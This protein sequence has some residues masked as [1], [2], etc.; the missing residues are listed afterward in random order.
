LLA[1][2]QMTEE[3]VNREKL[4][5]EANREKLLGHYEKAISMLRELH[6]E[7]SENAAVAYELGRLLEAKG[8][9]EEAIRFLRLAN[10]NDPENEWYPKYLADLYQKEGRNAEGAALYERLV[11][12][13][14]DD[15]YLYFR[16]A[17]FLVRSQE[18]DKA[19]KAYDELEKRIGLNEEI[20]RRKHTLFLGMGDTKRAG[21]EL[22]RLVEA[23]PRVLEYKHLLAD[24]YESQGDQSAARKVY[25]QI[26][27]VS[28]DDPEAL[29]A[30]AGGSNLKQ[31]ELR[32]LEELI[33]AFERTDVDLDLKISKLYPFITMVAE[34]GDRAVADAALKL[35]DVMENVHEA[36]AKPYAA[37]GDLLYYSNRPKEAIEKYRATVKR[38]ENVFPVWEQLLRSL[39]EIGNNKGLYGEANNALDV[40]PNRAIIQYYLAIAADALGEYEEALDAISTAEIMSGRDAGLL[41]EVKALEGQVHQHRNNKGEATTAFATARELAAQS[42]DV[43]YRYGLFLLA[44]NDLKAAKDA[45]ETAIKGDAEHPYYNFAMAGVAYAQEDFAKAEEFLAT[46]REKGARY[47]PDAMELSG[48]VQFKLNNVEEAVDFWQQAKDLGGTHQRLTDKITNRSL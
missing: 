10:D 44:N 23:F 15:Q 7:D 22:E 11:A 24:F 12:Q 27:E 5:I 29:L 43:N 41:A 42:P 17:Y 31:D 6:R 3:E 33:P 37:A 36:E 14:P 8:D 39:Y 9:M 40:F 19:I 16:W 30:L 20:I 21:R 34:T 47:W 13:S 28:P 18:V 1:Q 38:D 4:F 25:E 26:I 32:Y 35:T 46:A 45:L 48:D 2:G